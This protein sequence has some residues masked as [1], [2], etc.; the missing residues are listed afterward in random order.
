MNGKRCEYDAVLRETA[1]DG[2]VYVVFPWDIRADFRRSDGDECSRS[3]RIRSAK[4][5]RWKNEKRT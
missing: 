5:S 2:G 4:E 3:A 1:D